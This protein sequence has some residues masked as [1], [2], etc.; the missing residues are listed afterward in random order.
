MAQ[1]GKTWRGPLTVYLSGSLARP[2][3]I[4]VIQGLSNPQERHQVAVAMAAELTGFTEA[5]TVRLEPTITPNQETL[6]VAMQASAL[7]R[8]RAV[9]RDQ[10][11]RLRSVQPAWLDALAVINRAPKDDTVEWLA[12]EMPLADERGAVSGVLEFL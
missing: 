5:C 12:W 4:P 11:W 1:V 3:L 10:R 6:A 7:E 9:C 8:L 2:F